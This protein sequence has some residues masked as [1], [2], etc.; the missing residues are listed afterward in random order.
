MKILILKDK[1]GDRYFSYSNEH[2]LHLVAAFIVRERFDDGWYEDI[3][4]SRSAAAL[5][6]KA[7]DGDNRAAFALIGRRNDYEYGYELVDTETVEGV[8]S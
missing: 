6:E 1:H 7:I 2:E 8:T 4:E 3:K 5:L